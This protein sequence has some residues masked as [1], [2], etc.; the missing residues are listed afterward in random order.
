VIGGPK[1]LI[2]VTNN[3]LV[4]EDIAESTKDTEV[5]FIDGTVKDVVFA[6]RE[7]VLD[8]FKLAADPLAGRKARPNPYLSVVLEKR[9]EK[10][11]AYHILRLEKM[12]ELFYKNEAAFTDMS[13]SLRSDFAIIDY[14]LISTLIY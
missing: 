1:R 12:L 8:R 6:S 13:K 5:E 14:S 4:Y 7:K 11:E 10:Y 2:V 3:K 9:T